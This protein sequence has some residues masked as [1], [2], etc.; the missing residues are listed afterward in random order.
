MKCTKCKNSEKE[1]LKN[2]V[3]NKP[4]CT[5]CKMC[6]KC[7]RNTMKKFCSHCC[8][9]CTRCEK[10]LILNNWP[11]DI[12][13]KGKCE[14]CIHLC[15]ECDRYLDDS[16]AFIKDDFR[17]CEKCITKKF[18]LKNTKNVK[19]TIQHANSTNGK[20]FLG[21]DKIAEKIK[22]AKCDKNFWSYLSNTSYTT[23]SKCRKG[24]QIPDPSNNNK[25]YVKNSVGNWALEAENKKCLYCFCSIWIKKQNLR[26]NNNYRCAN[27]LPK[28]T[29]IKAKYNKEKQRWIIYRAKIRCKKCKTIKWVYAKDRK[30]GICSKCLL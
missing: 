26:K 6:K 2:S 5:V 7:R 21:C 10:L 14:K 11:L 23:C 24:N 1:C 27:C 4:I 18:C 17:Y 30:K 20:L 28:R 22:C 19:Y 3:N 16:K 12:I 15:T 29:D 13:T 9:K 25:K 8:I